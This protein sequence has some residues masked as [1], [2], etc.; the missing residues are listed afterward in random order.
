VPK[1]IPGLKLSELYYTQCV[2]PIIKSKFPHLKYSAGLIGTGSEI[3]GYDDAQSRDHN[4]GLRLIIFLAENG[5]DEIKERLDRQL[6]KTLPHEFM[7]YST[8]FS[9]PDERGVRLSASKTSGEVD[10]FIVFST[11]RSFFKEYLS[12]DP[13]QKLEAITWLTLPQQK[14][15]TLVR[16][17]IFHDDLG[18]GTIIRKFEYYPRNVWLFI[19]ASQWEKISELEAFVARTAV[20]GDE[21]GSKILA[22]RIVRYLMELC[23]LME[24]KFAPYAKWFGTAFGEL[25]IASEITPVLDH[26][27]TS[28]SIKERESFLAS[29]YSI[30]VKRHNSLKV[31]KL[32]HTV[33]SKYYDRPYLIIH[34]GTFAKQIRKEIRDPVLRRIP[35]IGSV[36]QLFDNEDVTLNADMHSKIGLF[37]DAVW[38][39]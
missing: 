33:V 8:S 15:L 27:L 31:T 35:L 36:D 6:R 2:E 39:R 21:L 20:V 18:L 37:F 28:T 9:K 4:W 22:S 26:V 17:R 11:M 5:F 3:L 13:N 16:G 10:H 1:F 38:D 34:A 14:L 19:L 25:D 32:M 24:K 12:I 30:V 29:A 7:G 23:F